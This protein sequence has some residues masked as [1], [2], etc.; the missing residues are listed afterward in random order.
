MNLVIH[1]WL[2]SGKARELESQRARG[3]SVNFA[4]KSWVENLKWYH[5]T[6]QNSSGKSLFTKSKLRNLESSGEFFQKSI[7]ILKPLW[8][9][10]GIAHT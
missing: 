6:L 8:S 5:T 4:K 2:K 10:S 7:C 1:F 3:E 9:F